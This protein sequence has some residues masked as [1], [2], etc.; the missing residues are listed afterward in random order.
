MGSKYLIYF[1]L[2]ISFGC[3]I[4]SCKSTKKVKMLDS[5]DLFAAYRVDEVFPQALS[6][7]DV[8]SYV[9]D[10]NFLQKKVRLSV[11]FMNSEDSLYGFR[12]KKGLD[13]M[14]FLI[15]NANKRLRENHKMNLPENNSSPALAPKYQYV[16]PSTGPDKSG[17]YWHYDDEYCWFVNK[18]RNR[19]NY[20]R[21]VIKKYSVGEDSILNVF[22]M[23][24]HKDSIKSKTYQ[25]HGTGIALGNSLKIA[26]MVEEQVKPWAFATLLN[27][28]VGHSLGL[29]HS[30]NYNDGCD[31]TPKNPNCWEEN[32]RKKGCEGPISNNMMDY[33]NS[34]MAISPCQ[35]GTMHKSLTMNSSRKRKLVIREWCHLDTSKNIII[36]DIVH[37]YGERDIS[38]HIIIAKGGQLT[39]HCRLSLPQDAEVIIEPGGQL[40][41]NENAHLHN[42]CGGQWKGIVLQD[43]KKEKSILKISQSAR[44]EDIAWQ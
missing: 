17:F 27:H 13:Y 11:H 12:K 32:K 43:S 14:R 36:S 37:W 38:S 16:V 10:E 25:G 42:D 40:L 5:E 44:I 15:K 1:I 35:L 33:N 18:G 2:V 30:W 28:E 8:L 6:C 23:P 22:V 3:Y 26:G 34:Q 9:P 24:H 4:S 21:D 31:D 20:N 19:N 39:V 41:L 7:S 29:R